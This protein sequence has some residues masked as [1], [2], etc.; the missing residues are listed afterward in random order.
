M[1]E[2]EDGLALVGVQQ[3][4]PVREPAERVLFFP[5]KSPSVIADT[6]AGD[7]THCPITVTAYAAVHN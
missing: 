4:D 2:L 7:P 6:L 1:R 3:P 5:V